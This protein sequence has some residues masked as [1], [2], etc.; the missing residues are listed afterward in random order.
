MK[1]GT[2][3]V[4][5]DTGACLVPGKIGPREYLPADIVKYAGDN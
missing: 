3:T 1:T 2:G 5:F 4:A